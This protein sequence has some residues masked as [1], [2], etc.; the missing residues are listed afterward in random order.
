MYLIDWVQKWAEIETIGA[1]ISYGILG[2]ALI[3]C[4]IYIIICSI[5]KY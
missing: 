2:L 5:N 4:I 3:L 1:Y